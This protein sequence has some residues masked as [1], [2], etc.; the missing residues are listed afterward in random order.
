MGH[1]AVLGLVDLEVETGR[2]GG[3]ILLAFLHK[4]IKL[5]VTWVLFY[6]RSES[7]LEISEK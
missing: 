7:T 5:L 3:D 4:E 1:Q 2:A 6:E